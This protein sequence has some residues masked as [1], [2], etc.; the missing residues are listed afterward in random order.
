MRVTF[1]MFLLMLVVVPLAGEWKFYPFASDFRVSFGTTAFFFFLLWLPKIPSYLSGLAV[2]I[3]VILFR[4]GLDWFTADTF[5]LHGSF[6][7][8]LPVFFFY[9]SF[10]CFYFLLHINRFLHRPL[11]VGFLGTAAE[12][13]GNIV[14]LLL[15]T[16][17]SDVFTLATLGKI[18]AFAILRSFF[19]LSF[20]TLIELRHAQ[21][22]E[23]QQRNRNAHILMLVSDLYEES[24]LLKKNLRYA[25]EITRNCYEFYRKLKEHPLG[26]TGAFAQTALHIAGQVHEI[27]K[28]NQRIYAGLSKMISNEN[29][30]DEM[31][32]EELGSIVVRA[33]LKYVRLLGK[34]IEIDWIC[35]LPDAQFP[36]YTTLSLLNNLVTNAVEAIPATGH[37]TITVMRDDHCAI[38]R[39]TDDGPGIKAKDPTVLFTPGFTTKYDLSGQPS[40]GIGLTYVKEMVESLH[41]QV[42]VESIPGN[43]SFIVKLPIQQIL[44]KG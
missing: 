28:D 17:A 13:M 21:K 4:I 41:G 29:A 22:L 40:T 25:E 43:T 35:D 15:R 2:G 37:I 44:K 18:T 42:A 3:T 7:H 5:S 32:L 31:R 24:I 26:Q 1:Y 9:L 36:I 30:A 16:P 19:V 10:G 12:I 38:L 11:L 39:V 33:N 6:L 27:K 23:V 34:E 14:E 8:Q 20:F